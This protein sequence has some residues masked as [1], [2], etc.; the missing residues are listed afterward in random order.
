MMFSMTWGNRRHSLN[1]LQYP[2]GNMV[3]PGGK[4]TRYPGARLLPKEAAKSHQ[5]ADQQ[6]HEWD[7]EW[8]SAWREWLSRE[9][10]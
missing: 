1:Q 2:M 9:M 5:H 6:V 3:D 10:L 8:K 4:A 7:A